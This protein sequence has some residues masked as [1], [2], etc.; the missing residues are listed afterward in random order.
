MKESF[1]PSFNGGNVNLDFDTFSAIVKSLI[2]VIRMKKVYIRNVATEMMITI[3]GDGTD[4]IPE[5]T[6]ESC[7]WVS[8]KK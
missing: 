8:D 2:E 6:E 4:F 7:L 1:R 5:V 3:P